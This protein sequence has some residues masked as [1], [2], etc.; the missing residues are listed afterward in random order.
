M[1]IA[2]C[3]DQEFFSDQLAG[4]INEWARERIMPVDIF[5]YENAENFLQAWNDDKY[6]DIIFLDI[7][8]GTMDGMELAKIIRRTNSDV[9]FVFVTNAAVMEYMET[10]YDLG[11]M[12]FLRK[13]I[14]KEKIYS[15][16][17]RV[18]RSDRI[19]KSFFYKELEKSCRIPYEDIIYIE[20]LLHYAEI[21]TAD[22]KYTFRR[23]MEQLLK[24]L[25]DELFVKCSRSYIVNIR[26]IKSI[27]KNGVVM[28]NEDIIPL[29]KGMAEEINR[30]YH[31]YSM[32]KI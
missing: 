2:I 27:S 3:E 23:T 20:K 5:T 17:D 14:K 24:E 6:Y 18:N 11:A 22:A 32:N 19:K 16:L 1:K 28:S 7:V 25:D 30:K 15:C 10:G 29:S 8:M 21:V 13:P 12:H 31:E 26:R 4:Y 9:A